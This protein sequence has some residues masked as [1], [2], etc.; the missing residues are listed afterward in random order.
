MLPGALAFVEV[1]R[2]AFERRFF[3]IGSACARHSSADMGMIGSYRGSAKWAAFTGSC[4]ARRSIWTAN[5]TQL[6]AMPRIIVSDRIVTLVRDS[7]VCYGLIS[8]Q[9]Y[10]V[11]SETPQ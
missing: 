4:S 8:L 10:R 11:T 5:A 9:P 1:F 3:E 7:L 6:L 2:A